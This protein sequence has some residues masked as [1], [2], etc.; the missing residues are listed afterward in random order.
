MKYFKTNDEFLL[1][2]SQKEIII[3]NHKRSVIYVLEDVMKYKYEE[4]DSSTKNTYTK[5]TI[6]DE[7]IIVVNTIFGKIRCVYYDTVHRF[8]VFFPNGEKDDW[9]FTPSRPY[10]SANGLGCEAL[11]ASRVVIMLNELHLIEISL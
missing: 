2:Q 11:T 1:E 7:L 8:F 9:K 6:D 10:I 4:N 5:Y 3:E